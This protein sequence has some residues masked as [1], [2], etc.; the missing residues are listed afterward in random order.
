[1]TLEPLRP[2]LSP[3]AYQLLETSGLTLPQLEQMS[4]AEIAAAITGVGPVMGQDI[5]SALE[6]IA[7]KAAPRL[8]PDADAL[9]LAYAYLVSCGRGR[10]VA[11]IKAS[12]FPPEQ[13]LETAIAILEGLRP[14]KRGANLAGQLRE[15]VGISTRKQ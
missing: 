8:T 6:H 1:M 14:G 2:H 5:R 11:N 15:M 9:N 3:R 13:K 12:L 4:A 7:L 10:D